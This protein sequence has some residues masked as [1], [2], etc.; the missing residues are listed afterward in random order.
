[1][2]APGYE[3]HDVTH[4]QT[5]RVLDIV[6]LQPTFAVG[7]HKEDREVGR[8]D[9]EA[10]GGTQLSAAVQ[11]AV[12]PQRGEHLGNGIFVQVVVEPLHPSSLLLRMFFDA[13]PFAP[14]SSIEL[15]TE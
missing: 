2:T 10:P 13:R 1:V 4:L 7:D 11:G 9:A 5:D 15:G 8:S 14:M 6:D 12:Y 3:E